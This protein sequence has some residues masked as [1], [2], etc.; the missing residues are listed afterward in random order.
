MIARLRQ[1]AEPGSGE[2]A[3]WAGMRIHIVTS[4]DRGLIH[5]AIDCAIG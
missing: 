2:G 5:H 4:N 3:L 1:V